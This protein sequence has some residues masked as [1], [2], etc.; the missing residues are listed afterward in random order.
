MD[1]RF[2]YR[3]AAVR[4]AS[5]VQLVI[6]LYEQA[7]EDVRRALAALHRCDIETR[8]REINHALKVI[9]ELQ[10]SLNMDL[11][12]TVAGNLQRFYNQVRTGLIEAHAKQSARLLEEQISLLVDL[13]EVW[14]EVE[15]TNVAVAARVTEQTSSATET[16]SSD[17]SA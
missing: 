8:T 4:G 15:R 2:F 12:G 3:E 7:I 5:A 17:W 9:G 16:S 13:R 10:G 6:L 1:A 11:G 14:A